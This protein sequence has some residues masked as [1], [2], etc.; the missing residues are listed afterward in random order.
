MMH[1]DPD[2]TLYFERSARGYGNAWFSVLALVL[3]A[4]ACTAMAVQSVWGKPLGLWTVGW[5][6]A[7][8]VAAL[9]CLVIAAA[10]LWSLIAN[11]TH[12]VQI[13][14]Q[15]G[16]VIWWLNKGARRI[17]KTVS[18]DLAKARVLRISRRSDYVMIDL[19]GTDGQV[20]SYLPPEALP[21]DLYGWGQRLCEQYPHINLLVI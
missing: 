3:V 2:P 21:P 16:R 8:G 11:T 17:E 13:D 19:L 14:T 9:V 6:A 20:L 5:L 12:G 1:P 7:W 10:S 18:I 15:G 4:G